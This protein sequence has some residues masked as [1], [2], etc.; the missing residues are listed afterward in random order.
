[1]KKESIEMIPYKISELFT[2]K[3]MRY[4][5]LKFFITYWKQEIVNY[6]GKVSTLLM[7]LEQNWGGGAGG[8]LK[9]KFY[10]TSVCFSYIPHVIAAFLV[11]VVLNH[12]LPTGHFI[13]SFQIKDGLNL[14]S[15]VGT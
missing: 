4:F 5:I 6:A 9:P 2:S 7:A 10:S 11:G 12:D 14:V 8:G 13:V 3:S 15:W 1:M